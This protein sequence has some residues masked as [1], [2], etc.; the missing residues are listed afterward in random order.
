M[1]ELHNPTSI[2][3]FWG[4][5]SRERLPRSCGIQGVAAL[6]ELAKDKTAGVRSPFGWHARRG[7]RRRAIG[8]FWKRR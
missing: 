2:A 7:H 3:E 8:Y 1:S 5:A 4:G 6:E